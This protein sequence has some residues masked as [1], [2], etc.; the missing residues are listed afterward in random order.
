M[1]IVIGKNYHTMFLYNKF[2]LER[3]RE[4]EEREKRERRERREKERDT[5]STQK[6]TFRERLKVFK[7][8]RALAEEAS[9]FLKTPVFP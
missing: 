6:L 7:K 1:L 5:T 8:H 2:S 3:E 4:R 9:F